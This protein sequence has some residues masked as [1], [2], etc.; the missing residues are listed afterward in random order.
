MTL[1]GLAPNVQRAAQNALDDLDGKGLPYAV[2]S[3]VR[4]YMEQ[5]A[6]FAQGRNSL[7][8]VN[9]RRAAAG[10]PPIGEKDN[11]YTVTR[12][13]GT[14]ASQGAGHARSPHQLGIA[15]DVVPRGEDGPQWPRPDD[16]RWAQI[17]ESFKA[18]GFE[19]G[20]DWADFPDRPHYQYTT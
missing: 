10:M 17:A 1:K 14:P 6:L 4:T 16:P 7:V 3:T 9:S 20:G 2:T 12:C 5:A 11:S 8:L 19:W 15:L 18:Q 13:D